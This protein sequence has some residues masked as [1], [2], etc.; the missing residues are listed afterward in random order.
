MSAPTARILDTAREGRPMAWVIAVMLF[1][2]LLATA[3]GL[4]TA[5]AV[6][7]IGRALETR[8]T[9]QIVA[10][11]PRAQ[12][13]Q[14]ASALAALRAMPGVQQAR[15]VPRAELAALLGPWIGDAGADAE[16]PIPALIDVTASDVTPAAVAR[17]LGAVAPDARVDGGGAA[18]AGVTALLGR[19]GM[20]AFAIV[21]LMV[22]ATLAVVVLAARAGL[23]QHG[24]T[25]AIMHSL[26]ATDVQVARLF[27]RR[28]TRD[29]ALGV[30]IGTLGAVPVVL[31]L[32]AQLSATG[33]EL[34]AA[35]TLGHAGWLALAGVPLGFI[36]LA[37]LTARA[38]VL[39]AL[40]RAL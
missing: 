5:R 24:E 13:S 4:A 16:L 29:A 30:A 12:A 3:G 8:M 37:A 17:A 7:A 15:P 19:V 38:T 25:I 20:L 9:V 31:L 22:A 26:G 35:A 34:L 40:A 33:S 10:A 36:A 14:A 27:Q 39:A 28:L 11:D 23:A 6:A 21:A 18:L 2:C 32:G 1:L